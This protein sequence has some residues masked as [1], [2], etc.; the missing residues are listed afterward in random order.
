MSLNQY[1]VRALVSL[2]NT[3]FWTDDDLANK[4]YTRVPNT[5]KGITIAGASRSQ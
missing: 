3:I 5:D 1:E 2:D 4:E